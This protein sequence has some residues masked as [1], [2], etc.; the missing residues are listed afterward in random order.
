MSARVP[1]RQKIKTGGLD[2]YSAERFGKLIVATIR[3]SARPLKDRDVN[4]LHFAIQV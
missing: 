1:E 2:Q 3:K 4:W